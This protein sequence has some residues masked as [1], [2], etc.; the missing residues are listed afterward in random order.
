ME[1]FGI[2]AYLQFAGQDGPIKA[3]NTYMPAPDLGRPT[4]RK[5]N[6]K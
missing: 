6:E 3:V 4:G 2:I 1:R 5:F